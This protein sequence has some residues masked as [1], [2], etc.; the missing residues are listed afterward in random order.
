MPRYGVQII[1]FLGCLFLFQP[2]F[3][4][5]VTYIEANPAESLSFSAANSY[6]PDGDDL[7]FSWWIYPEA[8]TYKATLPFVKS[9]KAQVEFH[10]PNDI[11]SQDMHLI[12]TVRDKGEPSLTRYR[13]VVIRGKQ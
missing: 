3:S 1:A 6:D 11:A 4:N 9:K 2:H 13:R 10:V 5:Q 8:G 12:L 7:E